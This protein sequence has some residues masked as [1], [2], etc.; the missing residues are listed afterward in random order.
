MNN[1]YPY[2]AVA[3]VALVTIAIRFLP[4]AVFRGRK[5]PNIINWLGKVLPPAVMAMLV[6]Y[7]LRNTDF[8]GKLHGIPEIVCSLIVIILHKWKKN[9]LLSIIA[10]TAL[11]M[12]LVNYCTTG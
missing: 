12:F 7:C 10:G 3:T 8:T 2:L 5:T 6:V 9:T 1:Y 11:Y 4:F